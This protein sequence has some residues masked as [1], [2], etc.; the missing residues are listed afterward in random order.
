MV[1]IGAISYRVKCDCGK[2]ERAEFG[3]QLYCTVA[4]QNKPPDVCLGN[5]QC[6][7]PGS[8]TGN[9][10][11]KGNKYRFV[12]MP[13]SEASV[14]CAVSS[15]IAGSAQTTTVPRIKP[16][17]IRNHRYITKTVY[18]FQGDIKNFISCL[19]EHIFFLLSG[20]CFLILCIV[21][22]SN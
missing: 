9:A 20:Q 10:Y 7:P 4:R 12:F 3:W 6:Y 14:P 8:G 16:T 18:C 22:T 2:Q 19:R 13:P 17:G 1:I 15:Q 21:L 11:R 5:S